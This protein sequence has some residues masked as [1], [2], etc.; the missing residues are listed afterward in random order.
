MCVIL[1]VWG[2]G[3]GG[4]QKEK[5][6]IVSVYVNKEPNATTSQDNHDE[7]ERHARNFKAGGGGRRRG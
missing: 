7:F 6:C 2:A 4:K 3:G 1:D 5:K